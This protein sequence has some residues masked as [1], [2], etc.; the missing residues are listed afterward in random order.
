MPAD[1]VI[2]P[3]DYRDLL[4]VHGPGTLGGVLRL[5]APGGPDGFNL[6]ATP[7]S[8]LTPGIERGYWE[9]DDWNGE[10]LDDD[11]AMRAL[12]AFPQAGRL[13]LKV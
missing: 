8:L 3:D 2:L 9:A 12:P 13:T 6:E 7:R 5:L 11:T 10:G 1:D 4:A